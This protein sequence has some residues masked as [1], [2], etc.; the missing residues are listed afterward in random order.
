[1]SDIIFPHIE[2]PWMKYYDK[3]K[4]ISENPKT[5]LADYVREKNTNNLNGIAETYYGS[6][7]SY[8]EL[9]D[10][11]DEYSK[12]LTGLGIKKDSRIVY[13][14]PNIPESGML[15]LASSQIGAVSDFIDPRPD[16]MDL[17]ANSRK[18][19]EIIKFEGADYIIAL[20]KCY[21]AMLKPIENELKELGI[22][23]IITLSATD[24]M[25]VLG[26]VDY[27]R[28]VIAYNN[29]RNLKIDSEKVKN[30]S[31]MRLF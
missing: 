25:N 28:D 12:M 11:V 5:N 19:L 1:M 23:E 30:L 20:D 10:R 15:W 4:L 3:E 22:N 26:K 18:I 14:V 29:L 7:T 9:L 6:K 31:F 27:L 2:R 24:S 8:K 16:S 13:L 21:L 17:E